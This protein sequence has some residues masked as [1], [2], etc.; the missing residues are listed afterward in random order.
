MSNIQKQNYGKTSNS[1]T[2]ETTSLA[3]NV[4]NH[5]NLCSLHV[6]LLIWAIGR[7]PCPDGE[8]AIEREKCDVGNHLQ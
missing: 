7:D 6:P 2:M 3:K 8:S 4:E 5:E 1:P